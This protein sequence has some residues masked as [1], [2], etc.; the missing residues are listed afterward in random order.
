M[1]APSSHS[2]FPALPRDRTPDGEPRLTGVEIEFSGLAEGDAARIVARETGGTARQTD[3]HDWVVEDGALGRIEVYLDTA[4]RKAGPD[5]LTEAGLK[6]GRDLI[7]VEIVT[8]PLSRSGLARLDAL[9]DVLRKAGAEGSGQGLFYGFGVHLNVEV[10]SEDA[11]GV[12]R[13]LLAYALIEDWMRTAAPID[14]SRRALPFTDPYPTSLVRDLARAGS[15]AATDEV[16]GIYLGHDASRNH[17][18]DMLPLFAHLDK[19]R[20]REAVD[21]AKALKGRPTFHFRLP[22]SRIDEAGW[23][24]RQE[25]E[26][27][28]LVERIAADRALLDR[29]A[30]A[31]LDDH[32]LITLSR[33]HWAGRCGE[34]L[35]KAGLITETEAA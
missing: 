30:E 23:S 33:S 17:G 26:R 32:G 20:V 13:P 16:I 5:R 31:W 14:P 9:R 12:T 4:L 27:W 29:L 3:T 34:L 19:D 1:T 8:E 7:P 11:A 25:W 28:R 6:L 2:P 35:K 21:H 10:A 18:L 24:L 15:G 22:D